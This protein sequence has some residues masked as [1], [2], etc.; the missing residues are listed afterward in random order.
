MHYLIIMHYRILTDNTC[1]I[2]G[3]QLSY[4]I[5]VFLGVS[6]VLSLLCKRHFERPKRPRRESN[7]NGKR[8]FKKKRF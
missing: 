7:K 1:K 4:L 6:V 2:L 3:N 8:P 5:Q